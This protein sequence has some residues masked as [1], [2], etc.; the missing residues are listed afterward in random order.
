ME[1][2]KK[3]DHER[4][5]EA[6]GERLRRSEQESM[7]GPSWYFPAVRGD[8]SQVAGNPKADGTR[9]KPGACLLYIVPA[10]PRDRLSAK[11]PRGCPLVPAGPRPDALLPSFSG[12]ACF[13]V[14]QKWT[15]LEGYE[16]AL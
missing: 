13:P 12:G 15:A 5:R 7:K 8:V 9:G 2:Q 6:R 11:P 16:E 4:A 3:R 1:S 14:S 10:A